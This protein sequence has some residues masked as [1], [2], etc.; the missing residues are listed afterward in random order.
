MY[1]TRVLNENSQNQNYLFLLGIVTFNDLQND[2]NDLEKIQS[3][4][5][6]LEEPLKEPNQQ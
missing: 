1:H 6:W 5:F 4:N 3:Y 2:L